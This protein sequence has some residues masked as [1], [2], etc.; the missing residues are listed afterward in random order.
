MANS[1]GIITAPVV[2]PTDLAAV[3]GI[4]GTSLEANC[5]STAINPWAKYKPVPYAKIDTIDEFDKST[6]KWKSTAVWWK[7]RIV[8]GVDS[9][10][11]C[12]FV[13][14]RMNS[15]DV[16]AD[17]PDPWTVKRPSGGVNE[18]YRLMDFAYYYHNAICPFIVRL[19]TQAIWTG[20]DI[21]GSVKI[22]RPS[23]GEYNLT[24]NDIIAGSTAY[25]GI[26]VIVGTA[27]YTKTQ[28]DVSV[29]A[30]SLE[31]CPLLRGSGINARIVA[32]MTTSAHSSWTG[33]DYQIWSLNAPNISFTVAENL[34]TVQQATDSYV[35]GLAGL[36]TADRKALRIQG[37][38]TLNSGRVYSTIKVTS[39]LSVNAYTL[40]S[41]SL[42]VTRNSDNVEVYTGSITISGA[43]PDY[44]EDG[45]DIVGT[46]IGIYCNRGG[47]TPPALTDPTDYYIYRYMFNYTY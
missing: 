39:R 46:E 27:V 12:G 47:Y 5:K 8:N 23:G 36:A 38:A 11:Y 16:Y 24:L 42:V 37:T 43:E 45:P 31:G 13:I 28:S 19:P 20:S 33:D 6:N 29:A 25:I 15:G 34:I 14:P 22:Q 2:M 9:G 32:F 21:R 41:I 35:I 17:D 3:L 44:I 40:S 7:N 1:G 26:A 10:A 4:S 18:P 30:I